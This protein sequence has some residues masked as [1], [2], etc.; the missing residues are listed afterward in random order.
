MGERFRQETGIALRRPEFQAK[1]ST[2]AVVAVV[3]ERSV[4]AEISPG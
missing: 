3:V 2:S 4:V 1:A